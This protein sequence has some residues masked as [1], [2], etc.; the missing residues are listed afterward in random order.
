MPD[1]RTDSTLQEPFGRSAPCG[2]GDADVKYTGLRCKAVLAPNSLLGEPAL[3]HGAEVARPVRTRPGP[4]DKPDHQGGQQQPACDQP[5]LQQHRIHQIVRESFATKRGEPIVADVGL[6]AARHAV[7]VAPQLP[8][9]LPRPIDLRGAAD[10][11]PST[12]FLRKTQQQEA[13]KRSKRWQRD[14]ALRAAIQRVW[15]D[16]GSRLPADG[17]RLAADAV[18]LT[19]ILS[20]GVFGRPKSVR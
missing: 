13:A 14:D 2:C 8:P 1:E 4:D 9:D 18:V 10:L 7:A 5:R 20:G 16:N 15:D 17:R 3:A 19:P 6:G 12:Y 11:A